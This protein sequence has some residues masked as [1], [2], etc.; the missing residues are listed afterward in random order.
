MTPYWVT[1]SLGFVR[2]WSNRDEVIKI[3]LVEGFI[4]DAKC[5]RFGFR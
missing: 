5:N 2:V 4:N 3:D 1:D